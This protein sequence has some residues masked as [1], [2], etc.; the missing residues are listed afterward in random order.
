MRLLSAVLTASIRTASLLKTE[1]SRRGCLGARIERGDRVFH[2]SVGAGVRRRLS[3]VTP[4]FSSHARQSVV[5][6]DRAR[7]L[8]RRWW[9]PHG[10]RGTGSVGWA[11]CRCGCGHRLRRIDHRRECQRRHPLESPVDL[12][13]DVACLLYTSEP[14]V[15]LRGAELTVNNPQRGCPESP[16]NSVTRARRTA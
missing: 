15:G 1:F 11:R 14:P 7:L 12:D 3:G 13:R 9:L 6:R 8:H 2:L 16:T 10:D 4:W 5:H